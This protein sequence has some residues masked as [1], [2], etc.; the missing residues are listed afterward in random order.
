M[1]LASCCGNSLHL[2]LSSLL[3]WMWV[4]RILAALLLAETVATVALVGRHRLHPWRLWEQKLVLWLYVLALLCA[5]FGQYAAAQYQRLV[6]IGAA[7][8]LGCP[9]YDCA[10]AVVTSLTGGALLGTVVLG[11]AAVT[12]LLGL[13]HL[14]AEV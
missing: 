14:A 9:S 7:G 5:G 2:D 8:P 11:A 6:S 12:L 3:V 4:G 13:A 1:I 10:Q